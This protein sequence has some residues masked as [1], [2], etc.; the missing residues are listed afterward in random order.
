MLYSSWM[1][2]RILY[3]HPLNER[4]R[5]FLRL[6]HLFSQ[7]NHFKNG[8]SVWDSHASV[9][10]LV[11][12]ITILDRTD[13]RSEVLK[14]LERHR[15]ELSRLLDMQHVDK[16]RLEKTLEELKRQSQKIQNLAN[17][18]S[19]MIREN[20]LLNS[21]RQRTVI[22]GG[23]CSFDIPAYHYWLHQDPH[24][25]SAALAAWLSEITPFYAAIELILDL[26]R[27]S[28][29]FE[30]QLAVNG[31]FQK[32]LE[33]Q[34]ACQLLRIALSAED[35]LY[36]EVSGN[37]HRINVRFMQYGDTGRAKH[38]LETIEFDMSC[39]AI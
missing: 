31:F 13:L 12:I 9:S 21:V 10:A 30:R 2:S 37:K 4:I 20:D 8:Y 33:V 15:H 17:K 25:K 19:P 28:T 26:I 22:S 18:L 32:S 5:V 6:E 3:E 14:E 24:L 1:S 27:N 7:I 16:G 35:G 39:C 23:T 36:P 11:E 38:I 34:Y 29:L